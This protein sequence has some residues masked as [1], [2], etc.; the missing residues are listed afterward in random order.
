MKSIFALCLTM[1]LGLQVAEV[2]AQV[3]VTGHV[4]AEVVEA[5]DASYK[6]ETCFMLAAENRT[7]VELGNIRIG[8]KPQSLCSFTLSQAV[9]RNN[10]GKEFYVHTISDNAQGFLTI[11]EQGKRDLSLTVRADELPSGSQYSGSYNITFAYN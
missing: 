5:A 1:L 6:G 9:V 3:R 8:G 10:Q 7:N 11:N 4:F 2:G